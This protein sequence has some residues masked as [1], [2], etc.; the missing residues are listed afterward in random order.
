M[1]SLSNRDRKTR[2]LTFIEVNNDI[3]CMID[4]AKVA[5]IV[6]M[7][8]DATFGI[9]M[10]VFEFLEI[11]RAHG[12]PRI[13]G[14]LNHLDMMKD[15]KALKRKKKVLKHRFQVELYPGAKL[16][17]LSGIVHGEYLKKE[18]QNLGRFIVVMKFRPLTWRIT[19]PYVVVDRYEDI[20]N[21]EDLRQNPKC[22]RN[23]V[24]YGYVRGVPFQRAQA[25]HIP[26]CGD[27]KMKNIT[28]L[29]DPCPLP[30][31][32]KKR[33]LNAKERLVFAPMSGVG[34]VL[35][36]KDAVYIDLGGSHHG[37]KKS[38]ADE[39]GEDIK[40][41]VLQPLL[42]LHKTADEKQ[43]E[44]K[45]QLFSNSDFISND[46]M[47]T[48][49]SKNYKEDDLQD[50][51]SSDVKEDAS[52]EQFPAYET[53]T[54]SNGI[55]RRRVLFSDNLEDENDDDTSD[56]SEEEDD[57]NNE[58]GDSESEE[59]TSERKGVDI[60]LP[61]K[62]KLKLDNAKKTRSVT[63]ENESDADE[64]DDVYD[65][66]K[67]LSNILKASDNKSSSRNT[68][69][70]SKE[71]E[72]TFETKRTCSLKNNKDSN[73]TAM[74]QDILKNIKVPQAKKIERTSDSG[75][76][77]SEDSD[78]ESRKCKSTSEKQNKNMEIEKRDDSKEGDSDKEENMAYRMDMFKKATENFYKN[79]STASFLRRYIYGDMKEDESSSE[80][81]ED[82]VGGL[83]VRTTQPKKKPGVQ[84]R[85]SLMDEIDTSRF[86][87]HITRDW[88]S[89]E[90]M[91][92]IRDCFVT[93]EWKEGENAETLLKMDDED[94][95]LY[96]DFE[97]IETG[98]KFKA[99]AKDG[100]DKKEEEVD[101]T[102]TPDAK[103]EMTA[104]EKLMEK[105]RKLKA[106][107]DAEYDDKGSG[108]YFES[109]K[110]ELS[111]QAELNRKEFEIL[112]DDT[113]V[114]YEGFRPGMYV[115]MEFGNFP[116]EFVTN[117]DPS[118][119]VIVGGLLENESNM[120]FVR[121]RIKVHRWYP[122]IL[123]NRDPLILSLGWR[124]FQSMMH[125]AKREDNFRMRSLKY[126]R[127]FLHVEAMFWGPVYSVNTG[128]VAL[129]NITDRVPEF[130][131]AANGV[132]LEADQSTK[133][134]KKLKLMGTPEQV[135]KKTAFIKDMFHS[136]TEVAKFEG[137]Q[138]QTQSG[139]RGIIKKSKGQKGIFRATFE[140]TIKKSDVIILKTWAPVELA[141]HCFCIRTLLLPPNEKAAWQGMKTVAQVK[142]DKGIR[143]N[144]NAD[145]AY[146]PITER[147]EFKNY[148]LKIPQ[149]LERALPYKNKIKYTPK[150]N[151]VERVLVVKD[152]EEMKMER[153][154]LRL[155]TLMSD[156]LRR[157]Q[158]EKKNKKAKY[159][160][161]ISEMEKMRQ[162]REKKKKTEACKKL[163]KRTGGKNRNV[164]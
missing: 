53:I 29:P 106:M 35:Y 1:A 5:D 149:G 54:D 157:E 145:S 134:V 24:L 61:P 127:K 147:N 129:Q 21:P 40:D 160:E 159:Q 33:S 69:G 114:Q 92:S 98:E 142:K 18:I 6:L 19:H 101:E 30:E 74:I 133:I 113:R 27:Y 143:N 32:L 43:A 8:I 132:V 162:V 67:D 87:P 93:G 48:V 96:G 66:E 151:K 90:L 58:Q 76:S 22:D 14:I 68:L 120:G 60:V 85:K 136:E 148:P 41:S 56:E 100:E 97:D 36:D 163:S 95:D 16:F 131:I 123:K 34:G 47:D 78:D 126:A 91:N 152:P 83:F 107:F 70:Q 13:M 104:K 17:Y 150:S 84:S 119:P 105:K 111:E 65:I 52:R 37:V 124:R 46:R 154:M 88:N 161:K 39:D 2:R 144:A 3:N 55:S 15:N 155:K 80:D 9:E 44:S 10:E 102:K 138:L 63:N 125:Y 117:F 94:E 112:D 12:A 122:K 20:T 89:Q 23:V 130:R 51:E 153:F 141:Q 116:C 59:E 26:G 71:E 108:E 31:Q 156:K 135:L 118:Y 28:F 128:F 115:R 49:D 77:S 82:F 99:V 121:V 11:C 158:L 79:Q 139:V 7:L 25:V 146:T 109:L 72:K 50:T 38:N 73:I 164:T 86:I 137:A 64:N 57:D 81:E 42:D 62:K 103:K 4:I 75:L 140:D 110:K 45:I